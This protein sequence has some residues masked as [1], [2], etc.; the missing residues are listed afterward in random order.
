MSVAPTHLPDIAIENLH[1]ETSDGIHLHGWV[2]ESPRPRATIALFH[3]MRGN[4]MRLFDRIA[5]LTQAG[6]RCVAFDLR[7]HG[8]SGG[9]SVS[10]G[11]YE[12]HDVIAVANL[13]RERWPNDPCGAIG[14]S[15]GGAALCFA[16][17]AILPFEAVILE[18]VYRDL[19]GAFRQRV[20]RE[21]PPWFRHFRGGIIWLTERRLGARIADVA[22]IEHVAQL[23]PRPVLC[24]TGGDDAHAPP[25]EVRSLAERLGPTGHFCVI[26]DVG[27]DDV[28]ER[29]GTLYRELVLG[30]FERHLIEKQWCAAA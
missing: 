27:H 28:C 4:R 23:A 16:A 18:S 29:G 8:E 5:F 25:E 6:Y 22:P 10:F 2:I 13:V 26:P 3:G 30:F 14:V 17:Q 24:L 12:R 1:C 7:A 21:Y 15:M 9:R 19:A 11:Y 20:G